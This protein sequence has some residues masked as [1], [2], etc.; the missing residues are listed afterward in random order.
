V[1]SAISDIYKLRAEG[2]MPRIRILERAVGAVPLCV[3]LSRR[4][5]SESDLG[6]FNEELAALKAGPVWGAILERNGI[7]DLAVP[8]KLVE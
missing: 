6:R 4:I 3:G 1:I 2:V 5:C 7:S 8:W